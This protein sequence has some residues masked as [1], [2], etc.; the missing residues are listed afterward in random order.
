MIK[1]RVSICGKKQTIEVPEGY[2]RIFKGQIKIGDIFY[3]P[4]ESRGT[5]FRYVSTAPT[6]VED[7]W[8]CVFRK[9]PEVDVKSKKDF[10]IDPFKKITI[11]VPKGYDL[12][13]LGNNV[14][15]VVKK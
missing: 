4:G 3:A 14:F 1:M 10:T 6:S 15:D 7:G 5:F 2:T 9:I 13:Q 12:I 8:E 11:L